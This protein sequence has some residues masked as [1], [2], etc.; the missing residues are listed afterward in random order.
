MKGAAISNLHKLHQRIQHNFLQSF[1][2]LIRYKNIY[3]RFKKLI[4]LRTEP[5]EVNELRLVGIGVV[6]GGGVG[7]GR[8]G[9]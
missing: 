9:R 6:G 7:S 4:E 8:G 3:Q 5:S 1:I 2:R